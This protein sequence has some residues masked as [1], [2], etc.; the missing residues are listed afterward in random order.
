M[1]QLNKFKGKFESVIVL[2]AKIVK[3]LKDQVP[4]TL[5]FNGGYYEGSS[6]TKIW[7]IIVSELKIQ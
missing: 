5:S 2:R 3:E 4:D 1:Q 6:H 7:L